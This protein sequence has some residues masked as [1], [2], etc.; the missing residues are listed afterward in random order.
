MTKDSAQ[1]K[2]VY[3][4]HTRVKHILLEKY[5]WAWIPILGKGNPKI[6][7]FD[8]FAGKG[9]Y[10]DGT[11]G[12]P[13]IAL[14]VADERA[15]YYGRIFL[16]F[17]EKDKNNFSDLE[18]VLEA[19]RKNLNNS[20]KIEI[21]KKN[22]VFANTVDKIFDYL[23]D[24]KGIL[25]PSFFFIDPFG[26]SG[27]PF[28]AVS[29]ILANPKTEIFFTFMARDIGRFIQDPKLRDTL[30]DLFGTDQWKEIINLPD[31]DKG[32]IQ[33][34][35]RQLHEA[36]NAKF[37]LH[38]KVCE[39]ERLRTLYYLIHATNNFDGHSIMKSVMFNQ[40]VSGD[41]AYLGPTDV[42]K[43]SQTI[44]FDIHDMG[45]LREFLLKR[46]AG[47]TLTYEK[48][49]E[50]ACFPWYSEPPYISK[51]YRAVLRELKKENKV[52]VRPVTSKT[53]RG[54]QKDDKITFVKSN[55]IELDIPDLEPA[56]IKRIPR[57]IQI[58][59]KEYEVLDGP[60]QT[61]VWKVNDGSIITRFDKTPI[62]TKDTDVVC[63][64]FI[65]LKWAYGCPFDCS[66]CYL[67]GTFRFQPTKSAPVIKPYEKTELHVRSFLEEA[68]TPEI[69]NTG[70]LADSLM[71]ENGESSFSKFIIPLFETQNRHKVLF[72]TKS[73]NI[74][75]LLKLES[76]KQVIV[77]F[78]LNALP[79]AK[80]W[81]KAPSV[82]KRIK[83][84][85]E[86]FDA[87][88]E[89]RIRIDPLVPI[90]NWEKH[91]IELLESIFENLTP[92][93]I[94]LGSLRG[95]QS[96]I[97]NCP[98]KTW[99]DY[100]TETSNWGKRIDF[101]T[102]YEIYERLISELKQNYNFRNISLCKETV[103]IWEAL[104]GKYKRIK[105]NCIW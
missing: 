36:A 74:K 35:R 2:W 105:C 57:R 29:R 56:S 3:R 98:D 41:F 70:E 33:L 8:G 97:N 51:H 96:T 82:N 42:T 103:G 68:K 28:K 50:E 27:I 25:V 80:T 58:H 30:T 59:Y 26:F 95:L 13:V 76:H 79:V 34:Y 18:N 48:I 1:E 19:E 37:S 93:R 90:K 21:I 4:E 65:E 104:G 91:Y 53:P 62:P 75:N 86:L 11:K 16:Y 43:R 69:L 71:Y 89:V 77:S 39:S 94:T 6:C 88:Y 55:P 32:L 9:K 46:F 60:K 78:T 10:E 67:K 52:S 64:H 49:Q 63:P 92:E 83:A 14:K 31:R 85:K 15:D 7:Y 102:R 12:S 38:F 40:S 84:A 81:E 100:L 22:D 54:M 17:I 101:S 24:K 5:L 87:G 45:Q 73:D 44:L 72:L 23:K 20:D 66:W 47:R 61:L 99:V